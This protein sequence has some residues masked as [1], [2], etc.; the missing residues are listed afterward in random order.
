[1]WLRT[2]RYAL[3]CF[4]LVR[5]LIVVPIHQASA[6]KSKKVLLDKQ[7]ACHPIHC[8]PTNSSVRREMYTLMKITGHG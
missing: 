4:S 7:V 6:K 2:S 5:Q 3:Q 8:E 1:M